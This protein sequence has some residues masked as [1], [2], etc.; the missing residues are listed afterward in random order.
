MNFI[1]KY[2]LEASVKSGIHVANLSK[3]EGRRHRFQAFIDLLV[4]A[5]VP[6]PPSPTHDLHLALDNGFEKAQLL[7]VRKLKQ[8]NFGA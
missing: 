3:Y 1:I 4:E 2:L 5:E 7:N 8:F 6:R